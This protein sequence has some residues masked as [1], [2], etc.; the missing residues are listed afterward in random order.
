MAAATRRLN[1]SMLSL[2]ERDLV[3]T[4][5]PRRCLQPS[6]FLF[7]SLR[8]QQRCC[9]AGPSRGGAGQAAQRPQSHQGGWSCRLIHEG[10]SCGSADR[11]GAHNAPP[12]CRQYCI[13]NL[14]LCSATEGK[15]CC[16]GIEE[17]LRKK[18]ASRRREIDEPEQA[19]LLCTI[20]S[21]GNSRT[22]CTVA[23]PCL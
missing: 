12:H 17:T 2:P 11:Q 18:Q 7:S 8:S 23:A 5:R 14:L 9:K 1:T 19:E 21:S 6:L 4:P 20:V 3:A 13:L 15:R 22:R 10:L 16:T